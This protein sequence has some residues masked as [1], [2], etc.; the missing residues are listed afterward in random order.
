MASGTP[1][2]VLTPEILEPIY[3]L[4]VHRLIHEG[5]PHLIFTPEAEK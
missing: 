3:H 1:E 5:R 4:R 2:E